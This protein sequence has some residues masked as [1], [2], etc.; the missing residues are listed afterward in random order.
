LQNDLGQMPQSPGSSYPHLFSPVRLGSRVI[1]N[2]IMRTATTTNLVEDGKVG[3]AMLEF[4][5][6]LA[7]GGVGSIV[8]ES[9]RVHRS[10]A[11]VP[12]VLALFDR[13]VIPSLRR[14]SQAVQQEQCLLIAQ[15]FHG[16]R[17]HLGRRPD[18]LWAP[19]A[20][21]CPYSG[22]TPHAMTAAEIEEMIESFVAAAANAIEGGV[23]GIEIHGGQGLR[24]RN[25]R[26]RS[27]QDRTG[28][29]PRLPHGHRRVHAWRHYG[30]RQRT[31]RTK[32]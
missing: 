6:V 13:D 28:A 18:T 15:L 4:Y 32:I 8:T 23:D 1:R 11:I 25:H 31:H 14:L 19:S 10:R 17:Q 26:A 29:H 16:G 9:F 21:A 3:N 30:R 7:C 22:G 5:R 20:I 2:R 24:Q 12:D 27:L